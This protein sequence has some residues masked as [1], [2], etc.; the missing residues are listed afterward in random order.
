MKFVCNPQKSHW[1][2]NFQCVVESCE[3]NVTINWLRQGQPVSAGITTTTTNKTYLGYD[4]YRVSSKLVISDF[5][6]TDNGCFQVQVC[7]NGSELSQT[8]GCVSLNL[9]SEINC[10][11]IRQNTCS[12][13][14]DIF[15]GK[16]TINLISFSPLYEWVFPVHWQSRNNGDINYTLWYLLI[17][18]SI[19]IVSMLAAS[20]TLAVTVYCCP[21]KGVNKCK[22]RLQPLPL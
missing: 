17:G 16:L 12:A 7:K 14:N 3:R 9:T 6:I 4:C 11:S 21:R 2:I 20:S 1:N 19:L 15:A 8:F 5:K 18:M 10:S 13:E 22:L